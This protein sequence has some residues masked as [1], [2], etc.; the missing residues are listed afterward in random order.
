MSTI[1]DTKEM[2]IAGIEIRT[3]N[4]E[5]FE[6]IPKLWGTFWQA[7][8]LSQIPNQAANDVYAVYTNFQNEGKNNEGTY[9]FVIG[10]KVTTTAGLPQDFSAVKIPTSRH[11][12]FH[13]PAGEPEK[14]GA[15]WQKIWAMD[16]LDKS[17]IVDYERYAGDGEISIYVGVK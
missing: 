1:I 13:L 4:N 14:V 11:R 6:T 16:D 15:K 12:V 10:A 7:S 9:S 5:A 17:Y 8:I 3:N 2:T